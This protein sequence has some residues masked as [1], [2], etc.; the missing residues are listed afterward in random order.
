MYDRCELNRCWSHPKELDA[1]EGRFDKGIHEGEF[2]SSCIHKCS[3]ILRF[4]FCKL[5][6]LPL[7]VHGDSLDAI[8]RRFFEIPS[9]T[10]EVWFLLS[11]LKSLVIFSEFGYSI[12]YVSTL[13]RNILKTV[14]YITS[15]VWYNKFDKD[16]FYVHNFTMQF[17]KLECSQ[18]FPNF[19]PFFILRL[20]LEIYYPV[21]TFSI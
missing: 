14:L 3:T 13:S 16:N 12:L 8:W 10:S 6:R 21:E 2:T 9:C 15:Y 5:T 1:E 7:H 18:S 4:H 11:C 19:R 20:I 17:A